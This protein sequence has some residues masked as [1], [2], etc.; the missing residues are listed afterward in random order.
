MQLVAVAE[1]TLKDSKQQLSS[2][3]KSYQEIMKSLK[4]VSV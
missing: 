3:K 2:E 1:A 4:E